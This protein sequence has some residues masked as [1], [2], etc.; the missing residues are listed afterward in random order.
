MGAVYKGRGLAM[1]HLQY[2]SMSPRCGDSRLACVPCSMNT[3][4]QVAGWVCFVAVCG[5][6]VVVGGGLCYV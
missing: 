4:M 6:G 3:V 1:L 5:G 2:D